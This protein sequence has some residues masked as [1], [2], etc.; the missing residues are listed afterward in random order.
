MKSIN[1][2]LIFISLALSIPDAEAQRGCCSWHGGVGYCDS[3]VG[4]QVCRD[5]TYSPS[6]VCEYIPRPAYVPENPK[7]TKRR[8]K[9]ISTTNQIEQSPKSFDVTFRSRGF[10]FFIFEIE[11]KRF[12]CDSACPDLLFANNGTAMKISFPAQVAEF[13]TRMGARACEFSDCSPLN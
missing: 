4:R 3:S 2:F 5:G 7:T 1:V 13:H 9:T 12:K 8:P 11:N 6:C 10:G